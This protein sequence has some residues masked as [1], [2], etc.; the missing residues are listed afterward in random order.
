MFDQAVSHCL[1]CG[2]ISLKRYNS[3][4]KDDCKLNT[5]VQSLHATCGIIQYIQ[6][7]TYVAVL[8]I[9]SV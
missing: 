3:L 9:T 2:N 8:H 6:V 7:G 5:V 4:L 1:D